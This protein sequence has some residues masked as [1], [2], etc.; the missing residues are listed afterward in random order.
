[1]TITYD[2]QVPTDGSVLWS[3]LANNPAG[4]QVQLGYK[5]VDDKPATYFWFPFSEPQQHNM[6]GQPDMSTAGQITMVMPAAALDALG[7]TWWWS[8]VI[9]V[10]GKDISTYGG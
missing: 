6:N 9:N 2:G 3:L 10:D 5:I 4:Q 7:D 8:S 1:M